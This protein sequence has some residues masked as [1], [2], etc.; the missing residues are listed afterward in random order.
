MKLHLRLASPLFIAALVVTLGVT[1]T[2][3]TLVQNTTSDLLKQSGS[4][5]ER[6]AENVL[7]E[8]SR[9][10]GEIA[11][12]M[13][14]L[15]GSVQARSDRWNHI[16]LDTVVLF[17][18]RN[19]KVK[20]SMGLA[21]NADDVKALAVESI[22]GIPILRLSKGLLIA[23]VRPDKN[24]KNMVV[25]VGKKIGSEFAHDLKQFLQADIDI[26]TGGHL[27]V[28][29]LSVSAIPKG[30]YQV[31]SV[32][33][34]PGGAKVT[35]TMYMPAAG[36][37]TARRRAIYFNVGIGVTLL[38]IA[39]LIYG[40]VLT[41]VTRPIQKLISATERIK[42]GDLH[43]QLDSQAPAELGAL[44]KQFDEMAKS[45]KATQER[46]VHS[47][48]LS[49]VG[50]LVAGI[51]HELNNPLHGLLG[52]AEH[53]KEVIKP[54]DPIRENIDR[55]LRE[56]ERMKRV[57][58]ELRGLTRPGEDGRV[59][60]GLN[61]VV[62]DVLS[63]VRHD[64]TKANVQCEM[65]LYKHGTEV[66]A[67]PDQIRQVILNLVLNAIQAMPDGGRLL[68]ATDLREQNGHRF[69]VV[70]VKDT[71]V[72]IAADVRARVMEPFFS[73]KPGRMGLGLSISQEIISRHGGTLTVVDS[74]EKGTTVSFT[75]P[76][77]SKS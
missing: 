17:D 9:Q 59:R 12:V 65:G 30:Y 58:G 22:P 53:V 21:V 20:S 28:S 68:L 44:V 56:G 47:A 13:S 2:M 46:L 6:I 49:S 40:Y 64:A 35:V 75:I 27:V 19:G 77:P 16:P 38:V 55:I 11:S 74:N 61:K 10:L 4:Q 76:V 54:D 25:L 63:L 73:T 51:S 42:A 37:Y 70:N 29:T 8:K 26:S 39:F 34:T 57:L 50:Q 62:E 43:V 5:L 71:G 7:K 23:G 48:K 66:E 67:S 41:R 32:L 52:H 69:F 15:E 36:L 45:L 72:G 14:N 31:S 24:Q 18:R 3:V 60:V 33:S 1:I